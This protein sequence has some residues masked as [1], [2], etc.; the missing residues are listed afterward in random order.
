M[1]IASDT[2]SIFYDYLGKVA[3]R[4][5]LALAVFC[6]VLG[7]NVLLTAHRR[8]IYQARATFMITPQASQ[9]SV[10]A[11]DA[12]DYPVFRT[13]YVDNCLELLRSR[14]MAEKVAALVPESILL[15]AWVL[16]LQVRQTDVIELVASGPTRASAVAAANAYLDVYQ[17][18]D[19]EQ[20]RAEVSATRQFIQDQLAVAVPRL[21]SFEQSLEQFKTSHRMANLDAETQDLVARQSEIAAAYQQ[22]DAEIEADQTQLAQ[23]QEQINQAGQGTVDRMGGAASPLVAS[24]QA[25]INQLEVERANLMISG[26]GQASDRV[27]N[28]DRQIDSTRAQLK[29]AVR[30]YMNQQES[31]RPVGQLSAQLEAA[32][33]LSAGLTAAKARKQALA[34]VLSRYDASL[35]RLPETERQLARLSRDVETERKVHSLLSERYEEE[36][37]QEAGTAPTVKTI[38]RAQGAFQ[39]Q[40]NVRSSLSLGVLLA[41]ALALGS[42]WVAEHLDTSIHGPRELEQR[43]YSV[44]GSIPRLSRVGRHRR[45]H[46]EDVTSHLVT[47]SDS[48][49]SGNETFRMLRSGL[50]FAN[51][52]RPIR[53]IAVTSPGPSEGKST[54]AVNLAAVL[55]QA[56]SRVLLVDADMRQPALHT[57]FKRPKEPGLSDVVASG[58]PAPAVFATGLDGLFC[59]PCGATPPSPSDLLTLSATRALLK[60]LEDEYDYV[61]IDTPPVMVAA[62]T[63]IIGALADTTLLVVR[64]GRTAL[65]ALEDTRVALVDGGAH[66][67]GIVVN[68][69]KRSGRHGRHYY[70]YYKY[71]NRYAGHP[72]DAAQP[73]KT[74]QTNSETRS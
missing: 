44:V 64:S 51:A 73:V 12:A 58:D 26:F 28:L 53:S 37:I 27:R 39:T 62:D 25:S 47:H 29:S 35:E 15:S 8:P 2:W 10:F 69:V 43:G 5:W 3:Q 57:F 9:T 23:V 67:S 18:Y 22:A 34:S 49:S 38:D 7:L 46:G 33:T 13:N 6:A 54:I 70:Y 71:H 60:R 61:V 11:S 24:L 14:S 30:T 48:E 17:Q 59:L 63:L 21:D 16:P 1:P 68:D 20:S 65:D 31:G 56:G 66:L 52:E 19:L 4:K 45:R 40:P 72:A 32:V 41:L 36:R 50:G 55:A 42:V 74:E